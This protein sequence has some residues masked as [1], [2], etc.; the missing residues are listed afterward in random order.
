[1][2]LLHL[3]TPSSSREAPRYIHYRD[4]GSGVPVLFL[5]G[6]WGYDIYPIDRQ[7][8]AMSGQFRFIIPDR[9]GYGG[10]SRPGYFG[11][12]FHEFA[13]REMFDVMDGLGLERVEIWGHSDGAVIALLMA[14]SQ[15]ERVRSVIA[16]AVH[17]DRAKPRSRSYFQAM[18]FAPESF[19]EKVVAVLAREHGDPYWK[20][21]MRAEGL[22]WLDLARSAELSNDDLYNGRL[23][24]MRVPLMV[25]HGSDDPRTEPHELN[26]LRR[27]LPEARFHIVAGGKH[28]PHSHHQHHAQ[29]TEGIRAFLQE[30]LDST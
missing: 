23:R 4:V 11:P 26:Q 3:S 25:L 10:S 19:G 18:A 27:V 12:D 8:E 20:E 6:G 2:N 24:E 29:A 30:Q 7:I 15:P 9:T 28:S 16:E 22:A 21:M 14:L 1:M 17:L 5:H 13:A